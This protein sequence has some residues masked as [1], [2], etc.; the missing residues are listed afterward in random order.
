MS[1]KNMNLSPFNQILDGLF[2]TTI[3][4]FVGSDA[5]SSHPRVNIIESEN[6]FRIDVAAP[7]L[8][9]EDFKISLDGD[10][11]VISSNKENKTE[12]VEN[13]EANKFTR[14]EYNYSTF[15][16]KFNL[17]QHIERAKIDAEYKNGVLSI[18]VPKKEETKL[19]AKTIEIS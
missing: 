4:D 11:L 2:N 1:R 19:T 12:T 8:E 5:I 7:G 10:D 14:R 3:G 17:P 15:N 13:T 6:D 18:L 9:K 16:R